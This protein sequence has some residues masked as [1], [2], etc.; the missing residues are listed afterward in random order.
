MRPVLVEPVL[1]GALL[2]LEVVGVALS[3]VE[4]IFAFWLLSLFALELVAP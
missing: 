2:G 1:L 3:L 4:V